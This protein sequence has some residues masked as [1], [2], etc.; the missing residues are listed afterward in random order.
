MIEEKI[1]DEISAAVEALFK[2]RIKPADIEISRPDNKKH[3]DY[4]TNVSFKAAKDAKKDPKEVAQKITEYLLSQN[5]YKNVE[6]VNGFVNIFLNKDHLYDALADILAQKGK[7]GQNK[8]FSNQKVQIEFVSANP[9]GP[10]TLGNSRGGFPGDALANVFTW[11]GAKVEREYY[12]NNAGN[13]ITILGKSILKEA[14]LLK[15]KGEFYSGEY[16]K[17]WISGHKKEVEKYKDDPFTL[18]QK[19]SSD[20]VKEYIKPSVE[21]MGIKYDVWF[22]ESDLVKEKTV[23]KVLGMLAK[24]NL[25]YEKD[26]ARWFSATKFGDEKDRV[27]VKKDGAYTYFAGDVAYHWNKFATRKFDK[28]VDIWGADHHGDVARVFGGVEALGFSEKLNIILTQF[29]RLVKNGKEYKISKR[30]G[31]YITVD[32]LISLIGGREKEASDVARFFFLSRDFNTHMDFDLDLAREHSEKNP[33]YYVKYAYARIHGILDKDKGKSKNGK[34]DLTLLTESA[35]LELIDQ[36]SELPSVVQS[37][38]M[39]NSYPVHNLTFYAREVASKFH[40]F[41][42]KCRV[43]DEKEPELTKARLAL[44]SAAKIVLQIVGEE[45]I[46]IE[47]PEKM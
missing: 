19:A 24:K 5:I 29:V 14:G 38:V 18:G 31:T 23:D 28:V 3:G 40:T 10:L 7:Y 37:I 21:K 30:K 9:T 39:M 20:I 42:D 17:K 45:L 1:R 15:E 22:N 12:L 46:G 36:L 32:D 11:C 25:L 2:I 8:L 35:E 13:Q 16:I 34:A 44:V 33:V 26:G 41:Y 43:V 4:S 47:M 27:A 6:A